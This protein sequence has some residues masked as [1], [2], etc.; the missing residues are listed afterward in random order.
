LDETRRDDTAH[1]EAF[2]RLQGLPNSPSIRFALHL[3]KWMRLAFAQIAFQ[4]WHGAAPETVAECADHLLHFAKG[5]F[6]LEPIPI[7]RNDLRRFQRQIGADENRMA[8]ALFDQNKAK[9]LVQPLP[10]QQV[11]AQAGNRLFLS[12][13]RNLDGL[14]L[15]EFEHLALLGRTSPTG[16]A[17][18]MLVGDCIG[19]GFGHDVGDGMKQ[20]K[21]GRRMPGLKKLHQESENSSKGEY[22]VHTAPAG[23]IAFE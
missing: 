2:D 16:F 17:D 7:Q 4:P 23:T 15:G 13:D 18:R 9:F 1:D 11:Q 5:A 6:D 8:V 22:I 12:V 14:E 19:F 10:P 21:E 20:A 3:L